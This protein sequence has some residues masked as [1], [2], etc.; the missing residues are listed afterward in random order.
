MIT[1]VQTK[2]HPFRASAVVVDDFVSN[3]EANCTVALEYADEHEKTQLTQQSFRMYLFQLQKMLTGVTSRAS[4]Y[5]T[6]YFSNHW[7]WGSD[8]W[9]LAQFDAQL[10]VF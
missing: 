3:C 4:T 6:V 5:A 2:L 8:C 10:S 7:Y 1:S 9:I